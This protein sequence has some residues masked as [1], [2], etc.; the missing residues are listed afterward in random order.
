[1]HFFHFLFTM[2]TRLDTPHTYLQ[3]NKSSQNYVTRLAFFRDKKELFT[4]KTN[5]KFSRILNIFSIYI[6]NLNNRFGET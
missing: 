5:A 2:S 4:W 1:M 6:S 3:T